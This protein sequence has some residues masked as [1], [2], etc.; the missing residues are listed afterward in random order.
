MGSTISHIFII[1][2]KAQDYFENFKEAISNHKVVYLENLTQTAPYDTCAGDI[3]FVIEEDFSSTVETVQW[4]LEKCCD[5]V[6]IPILNEKPDISGIRKLGELG[7]HDYLVS[8]DTT[9]I[10]EKIVF[11]E[12]TL[13]SKIG[14]EDGFILSRVKKLIEAVP[15]AYYL[16][17]LVNGKPRLIYMSES[18]SRLTGYS[19]E[20]LEEM[21]D[22]ES[23]VYRDDIEIFR[24]K[25]KNELSQVEYRIVGKRYERIIVRDISLP[26]FDDHDRLM[27]WRGILID[28]SELI[29]S[30]KGTKFISEVSKF[31]I[32]KLD[33]DETARL[34]VKKLYDTIDFDYVSLIRLDRKDMYSVIARESKYSERFQDVKYEK[35][36]EDLPIV[37]MALNKMFFVT[38]D[39]AQDSWAFGKEFFQRRIQKAGFKA[40][41]FFPV[42]T[43]KGVVFG[44]LMVGSMEP[45]AFT[46]PEIQFFQ[47][48]SENIGIIV[49]AVEIYQGL[50]KSYREWKETI[51]SIN[52]ILL[53]LTPERKVTLANKMVTKLTGLPVSEILGKNILHFLKESG[54]AEAAEGLKYLLLRVKKTGKCLSKILPLKV[55]NQKK[56]LNVTIYPRGSES[57]TSPQKFIIVAKDMTAEYGLQQELMV[58]HEKLEDMFVELAMVV[59]R[60]VEKR[61]PYTF[62]HSENVASL[63]V[64]IGEKLGLDEKEL[65]GLRIAA[66]LHDSGKIAVP[67][68]ILFKPAQLNELEWEFMKLHP[69][70]GYEF[71]KNVDFL[72]PVAE[73]V[74]QH[75][76]R[77]DGSGYP[78]GL[79][80]NEITLFARIIAV[81][82]VVDAITSFRPYRPAIPL[83]SAIQEI[84]AGRGKKYD[85][86]VVDACLEV[87]HEGKW[88]KN[89]NSS[90]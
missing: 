61:D 34:I 47:F 63:S 74:L 62:G 9:E 55:G 20:E 53:V 50:R 85:P 4:I 89:R 15:A 59:G 46:K 33:I 41:G 14:K 49:H 44:M 7:V 19:I 45:R 6:I 24:S 40:M 86:D 65:I 56:Y 71:I 80:G 37:K 32:S 25:W 68:E 82:D 13:K 81:A 30:R 72:W 66:L 11:L 42:I 23:L 76:E 38:N 75:H 3:M 10:I 70:I 36:D 90:T 64:L 77:L 31:S 78:Y 84:V 83:E 48:I 21:E 16:F 12:G 26:I 2:S 67:A 35:I 1:G 8:P 57:S 73:G 51:D 69:V 5:S 17:K 39:V 18:F 88:Q 60:V 79:K 52:D 58:Y 54:N 43:S 29:L 27:G 28:I 87:I 22:L